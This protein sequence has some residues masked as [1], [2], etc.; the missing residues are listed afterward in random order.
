LSY[1]AFL[2][3]RRHLICEKICQWAEML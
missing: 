1:G 3:E 2:V